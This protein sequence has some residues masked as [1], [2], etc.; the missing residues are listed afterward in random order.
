[1]FVSGRGVAGMRG[2]MPS[3]PGFGGSGG[4]SAPPSLPPIDRPQ[5]GA[6]SPPPLANP[7]A[8]PSKPE[9]PKT[10]DKPDKP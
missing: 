5:P 9:S 4:F 1:M 6:L 7:D 2:F 8:K 3:G 10:P